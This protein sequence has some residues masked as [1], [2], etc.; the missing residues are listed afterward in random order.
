MPAA[1]PHTGTSD[2]NGMPVAASTT[3]TP[4]TAERSGR[5]LAGDLAL[6]GQGRVLGMWVPV[7]RCAGVDLEVQEVHACVPQLPPNRDHRV[8]V[9]GFEDLSQN[10]LVGF[11]HITVA[12]GLVASLSLEAS[13]H[14]RNFSLLPRQCGRSIE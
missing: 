4:S 6:G 1:F 14:R 2:R 3:R 12:P 9:D 7:R 13:E 5:A 8:P 10:G 11:G